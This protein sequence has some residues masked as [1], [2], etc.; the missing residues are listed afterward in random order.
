VRLL[1]V[2]IFGFLI[3]DPP[4]ALAQVPKK[5]PCDEVDFTKKRW[6]SPRNGNARLTA[7][8]RIEIESASEHRKSSRGFPV[9][10]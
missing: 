4:A 5:N 6:I 7:S 9:S 8:R 3:V 10:A 2:I 1:L